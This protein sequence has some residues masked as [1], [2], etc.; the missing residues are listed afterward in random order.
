MRVHDGEHDFKNSLFK[1]IGYVKYK[2]TFF[3]VH[4]FFAGRWSVG[5]W[6]VKVVGGQWSVVGWSVGRWSVVSGRLVDGFKEARITRQSIRKSNV[7][8]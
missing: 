7:S 2:F 8:T 6:S 4:K 3:L 5:Q 1:V